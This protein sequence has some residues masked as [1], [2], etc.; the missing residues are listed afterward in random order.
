[1]IT[2]LKRSGEWGFGGL[3]PSSGSRPSLLIKRGGEKDSDARELKEKKD[4]PRLSC[5]VQFAS[6]QLN[7]VSFIT[8]LEHWQVVSRAM[9]PER[10]T[11]SRRQE[12]CRSESALALSGKCGDLSTS[13]L[14]LHNM[15]RWKEERGCHNNRGKGPR[16]EHCVRLES[17]GD[18]EEL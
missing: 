6:T 11:P 9:Q 1:M 4:S 3:D 13:G 7:V 8:S 17:A 15:C 10:L 14:R 18:E 12:V 5:I 2:L 16:T